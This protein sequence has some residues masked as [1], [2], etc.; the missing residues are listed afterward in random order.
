[1]NYNPDQ[2]KTQQLMKAWQAG[3]HEI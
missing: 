1:V 3:A 2:G